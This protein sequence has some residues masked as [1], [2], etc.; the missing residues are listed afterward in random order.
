MSLR[1]SVG[2]HEQHV[3]QHIQN[4][5][6]KDGIGLDMLPGHA[7]SADLHLL[8]HRTKQRLPQDELNAM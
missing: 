8:F 2:G 6:A 3:V 1:G 5:L 7:T 4:I